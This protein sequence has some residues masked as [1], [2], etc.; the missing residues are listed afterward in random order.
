[1]LGFKNSVRV[2]DMTDLEMVRFFLGIEGL[3]KSDY[4]HLSMKIH[5]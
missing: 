1:M 4:F 5:H 3:Q 2:F